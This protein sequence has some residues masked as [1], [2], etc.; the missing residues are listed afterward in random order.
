MKAKLIIVTIIITILALLV[1]AASNAEIAYVLD[2]GPYS[3]TVSY[4]NETYVCYPYDDVE[5]DVGEADEP[6]LTTGDNTGDPDCDGC[7]RPGPYR[8]QKQEEHRG[9]Q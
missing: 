4:E 8:Y 1:L 2:V 5:V 6:D 9:G 3:I 7:E